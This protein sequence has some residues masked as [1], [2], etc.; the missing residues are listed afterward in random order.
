[1]QQLWD[2]TEMPYYLD[3]YRKLRAD[4][5]VCNALSFTWT[6]TESLELTSWSAM[7]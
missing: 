5:L 6:N 1:M 2:E 7:R 4:V 3:E